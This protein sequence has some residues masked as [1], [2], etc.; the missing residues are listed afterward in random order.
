M[1]SSGSKLVKKIFGPSNGKE[2]RGRH[3]FTASYSQDDDCSGF[4]NVVA[5][6]PPTLGPL[7][8]QRQGYVYSSVFR[9]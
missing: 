7:V 6:V 1:G 8:M 9:V 4:E 5:R 3:S 2:P